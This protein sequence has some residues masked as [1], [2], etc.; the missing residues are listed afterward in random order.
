MSKTHSEET[1]KKISKANT[2]RK[3]SP[4][5]RRKIAKANRNR[6]GG[7]VKRFWSHVDKRSSDECWNWTAYV[8]SNGYG[9]VQWKEV[10]GVSV[11]RVAW[12]LAY[13]PIPKQLFV[14]HKC[15]NRRCCNPSHL[16]L[17][18]Q[19]DN[20]K[21][22]AA[23]GRGVKAKGYTRPDV[24]GELNNRAG[25]TQNDVREIR[26]RAVMGTTQKKLAL[27]YN[28]G[29]ATINSIVLRKTWRHVK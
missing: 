27:E 17:G 9:R 24:R 23:K 2:G 21:D 13:G 26:R 12:E 5:A 22:M 28:V 14:L 6:G 20:M 7:Q 10:N 1:K 3:R 8:A 25:L 19:A 16:F 11:H 29:T 18:S 4:E 15:D